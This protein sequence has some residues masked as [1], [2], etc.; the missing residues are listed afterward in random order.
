MIS[1][2]ASKLLV[3]QVAQEL[4]A[5]QMYMGISLYFERQ[6]LR[7]WAKLFHDQAVEEAGHGGKIMAFLID[8]EVDFALPAVRSAPTTYAS[9]RA[10]VETALASEQKVTGLFE[11]LVNTCRDAQ[12][13][14]SL[15]FL[16]WFVEE[17]VEEERTA[18]ALLDLIDSGINLFQAESMLGDVAG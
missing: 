8:N 15:Q 5:H 11:T 14:R 12:D 7:G 4:N 9:A 16:W 10:A 2:Q 6:S 17:Q 3:A 18:R 13:N 1:E